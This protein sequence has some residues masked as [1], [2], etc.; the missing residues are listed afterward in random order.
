MSS[1]KAEIDRMF[2]GTDPGRIFL[3]AFLQMQI[4]GEGSAF[5][6]HSTAVGR[7]G[8]LVIHRN[9]VPVLREALQAVESRLKQAEK[10]G[11]KA[12]RG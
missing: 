8:F 2:D 6:L 11:G 9:D 7:D 4:L 5:E 1:V 12:D 3:G 10:S